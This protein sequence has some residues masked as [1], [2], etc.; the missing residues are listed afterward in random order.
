M[1]EPKIS[2]IMEYRGPGKG[3]EA[4]V[5]WACRGTA[6]GC[7]KKRKRQKHCADCMECEDSE[8]T[9]DH[10]MKRLKRGNA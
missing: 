8:E 1:A 2:F 10:I 7:R 4:Y 5:L 9:L 6:K 3:P